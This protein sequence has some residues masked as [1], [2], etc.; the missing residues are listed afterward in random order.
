MNTNQTNVV[1]LPT[2]TSRKASRYAIRKAS[3]RELEATRQQAFGSA[4]LATVAVALTVLSLT[5]LAHGIAV[6]TNCPGWEA[7]AMAVGVDL[8]FVALEIAKVT[9]RERTINK[10]G[11]HLKVAIVGTIVASSALNA[12]AFGFAA[13]GWLVYPAVILGLAIPAMVYVLTKC[14]TTMWLDR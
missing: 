6:V 10:I 11:S 12:M 2:K 14:G 8:G 13:V 7:W 9:S 3:R 4:V 5:H 1:T